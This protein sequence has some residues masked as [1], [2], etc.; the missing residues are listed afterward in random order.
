VWIAGADGRTV[1]HLAA[2]L[3]GDNPPMPFRKGL[4]QKIEWDMTDDAGRPAAGGPFRVHVG[5]GTRVAF[6]GILCDSR[7]SM[8]VPSSLTVD[9]DGNLFLLWQRGNPSTAACTSPGTPA[10]AGTSER[11][12]PTARTC[13]RTR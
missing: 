6:D 13:R 7:E 3:L 12:C 1:R 8:G 5:L 10:T 4:V 9:K 2:G 11:S